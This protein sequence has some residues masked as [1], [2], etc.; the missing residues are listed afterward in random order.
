MASEHDCAHRCCQCVADQTN[1]NLS[2]PQ[3]ELLLWHTKLCLNMQDLQKLMKPHE[4]KGQSGNVVNTKPAVIPTKYKSTANLKPESYPLCIACKLATAKA[5]SDGV[6]T[7]TPV[8]SK[9]GILAKDKYEPGDF[10]STDQYIV[11]TPGRLLSGYGREALHN[12]FQGGTIYQDAA[13]KLVRVQN[14][15]SLG[16]GETTIGK[17]AFED[18]IWQLA[19]V[20]AQHYHSDNGIF[21]SKL[22]R[23]HCADQGQRQT[24]S[25]VGAKHQNAHAERTIQ[26]ISYW[27]RAMMV[28]AAIHWPSDGADD[29]RLWAFAINH[30]AWLYNRMPNKSLGWNTPLEMF[31]K[32]QSDHK[33]LLRAKVWG[34]P[35]FVLQAK[36]QDGHK[37]PK[38]NRRARMGQFLG[39]SDE[40]STLVAKVRHLSTNHVSPQ[41][42][43]VFDELFTTI[44]NDIKLTDPKIET[45]F[46]DLFHN[47]RENFEEDITAPEGASAADSVPE[48]PRDESPELG[49][50]W[51]SEPEL[52]DQKARVTDRYARQNELAK[53]QAEEFEKL[54]EGYN[55]PYPTVPP[56]DQL[57]AAA[58]ISDPE[59]DSDNDDDGQVRPTPA[60]T[61]G[62]AECALKIT[63]LVGRTL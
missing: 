37:I 2:G 20:K 59:S 33:E 12:C 31:T 42:H 35:V 58:A 44:Y 57:P 29:V 47:C 51:L 41:F 55:P 10:I 18:W 32:T 62:G 56:E 52:R 1:Q 9:T 25:G 34:C 13:S 39:F 23:E 45:I 61:V 63:R 49:E 43:V 6:N 38:F 48:D 46:N 8:P 11:R 17:S 36:L 4:I 50:E 5:R 3:K 27:A 26:T 60:P 21:N 24:F 40:H 19:T 15:V 7:T 14:Q 54:N 28:H 53:K 30:A 16:T 22:F